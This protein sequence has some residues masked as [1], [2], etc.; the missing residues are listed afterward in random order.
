[1]GVVFLNRDAPEERLRLI[2]TIANTCSNR[3]LVIFPQGTTSSI[4]EKMPFNRG[5]FKVVE[6]NPEILLLPL[7]LHYREDAEI[8]WNKPQSFRENAK[9]VCAQKRIHVTVVIHNPVTVHDYNEKTS[10]Q[11][12]KM[13]ER[14]VLYP[15]QKANRY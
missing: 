15:L 9:R 3:I 10:A 12:C 2:R 6:L 11:I 13:V 1:M 14:T 8:A 5:I 7:T 4:T